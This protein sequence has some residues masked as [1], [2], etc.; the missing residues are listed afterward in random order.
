MIVDIG[1]KIYDIGKKQAIGLLKVASKTIEHG[2]YAVEMNNVQIMLKEEYNDKY[3][4][5]KAI[6]GYKEKGFKVH[7][8]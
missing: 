6:R 2:I 3:R 5:R 7:W 8:K 1:G 4:L